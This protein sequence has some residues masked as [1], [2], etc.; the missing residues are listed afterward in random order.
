VPWGTR[1]P[2]STAFP[3]ADLQFPKPPEQLA[4][5][6]RSP[7]Q[8]TYRELRSYIQEAMR[9]KQPVTSHELTLYHKFSIPFASLV[10][11][12]IAPALGMRSHRGSGSIGMGLAILIGFAYYVIYNYLSVVAQQGGLSPLWA[13]WLPNLVTAVVGVVLVMRVRR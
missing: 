1:Y 4:R 10:F 5:E 7:E 8:M 11:A 12:L 6:S 9:R 13:A 2:I 3:V